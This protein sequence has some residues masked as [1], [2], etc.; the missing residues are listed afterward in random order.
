VSN[1]TYVGGDFRD[2]LFRDPHDFQGPSARFTSLRVGLYEMSIQGASWAACLPRESNAD[3]R[4]YT[5]FEVAY[6]IHND[7]RATYLIPGDESLGRSL[8][9]EEG[10]GSYVPVEKVQTLVEYLASVGV[11]EIT[12]TVD[13]NAPVVQTRIDVPGITSVNYTGGRFQDSTFYIA[14]GFAPIRIGDFEM[15]VQGQDFDLTSAASVAGAE[16]NLDNFITF[17][18]AFWRVVDGN[19][20]YLNPFEELGNRF[21]TEFEPYWSAATNIGSGLPA[22]VVQSLV[23]RMAIGAGIR[24]SA[25]PRARPSPDFES[26]VLGGGTYLGAPFASLVATRYIDRPQPAAPVRTRT[27]TPPPEPAPEPEPEIVILSSTRKLRIRRA[28]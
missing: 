12:E 5:H 23:D 25:P 7:R 11:I 26:H 22:H 10:I 19:R 24:A 27:S 8:W 18:A 15:V 28:P 13:V 16:R 20:T 14:G 2:Y 6:F 4:S 1:P 9:D 17:R 21:V 3:A